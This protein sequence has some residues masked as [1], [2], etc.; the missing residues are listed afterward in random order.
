MLKKSSSVFFVATLLFI[1]ATFSTSNF[2][3]TYNTKDV[4]GYPFVFFQGSSSYLGGE[5]SLSILALLADISIYIGLSYGIVR[6]MSAV[7][8]IGQK[9]RGIAA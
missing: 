2:Q 6:L 3:N 5:N 7:K 8:M 9:S 1:V 4:F